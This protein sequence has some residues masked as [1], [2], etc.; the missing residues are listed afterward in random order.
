MVLS[1]RNTCIESDNGEIGSPQLF[2]GHLVCLDV[3]AMD[4]GEYNS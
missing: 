3:T 2:G 1:G 4:C